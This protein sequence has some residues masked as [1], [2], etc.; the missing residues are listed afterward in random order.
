MPPPIAE[1][2][3]SYST[4]T[5]APSVDAPTSTDAPSIDSYHAAPGEHPST[6]TATYSATTTQ[7]VKTGHGRDGTLLA[8][9]DRTWIRLAIRKHIGAVLELRTQARSTTSELRYANV[10]YARRLKLGKQTILSA[11][12]LD[13]QACL[14]E[15]LQA[16]LG[17]LENQIN[18]GLIAIQEEW[19][20]YLRADI[21]APFD[22]I[23]IKKY[24]EVGELL[25]LDTPIVDIISRGKIY[26]LI[27]VPETIAGKD[28]TPPGVTD[29]ASKRRTIEL[30]DE[31]EVQ[32]D[33]FL[34]SDE[35]VTQQERKSL[36]R[37]G[38]VVSIL[39]YGTTATRTF[40]VRIELD[41][42]N[43]YLRAGYSVTA[44]VPTG[45]K[46]TS[47]VVNRDGVLV[48]PAGDSLWAVTQL[49]KNAKDE[50][51]G[52]AR[53]ANV[54]ITEKN[55]RFAG[56]SRE[57]LGSGKG[58]YAIEPVNE[59]AAELLKPRVE[60][61]TEGAETAAL[62]IKKTLNEG[63]KIRILTNEDD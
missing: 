17:E 33:P 52:I 4:P 29:S 51:E 13:K 21:Y 24:A 22:G 16:K 61:L 46:H 63:Q 23:V 27:Y 28:A 36:V 9:V 1:P 47:F 50:K 60:V 62:N 19:E 42:E 58:Y 7:S 44:M 35:K 40:P 26:A 15:T 5:D 10:E 20:R 49:K 18:T 39:A 6:S 37:K 59:K 14:V 41:D 32:I 55:V 48:S 43:G 12:A 30:G 56:K 38:K 53:I 25:S 54:R 3:A 31:I 45:P 57:L 11:S 2:P 34:P 8:R